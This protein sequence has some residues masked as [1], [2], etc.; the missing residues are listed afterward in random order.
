MNKIEGLDEISN[1][2]LSWVN[3]TFP[4]QAPEIVLHLTIGEVLELIQ[5][6]G[7]ELEIADVF[8]SLLSYANACGVDLVAAV[9]KKHRINTQRVFT[10][11]SSG[12]YHRDRKEQA[13]T[14]ATGDGKLVGVLIRALDVARLTRRHL[15]TRESRDLVNDL[16]DQ[17]EAM[18]VEMPEQWREL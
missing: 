8:I 16:M 18:G 11:D 5:A 10:K 17:L 6:P 13:P 1:V 7:D 4:E 9:H 12:S 2:V 14:E 15:R 3:A